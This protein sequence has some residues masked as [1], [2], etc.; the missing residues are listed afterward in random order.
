MSC[1]FGA[2][3]RYSA[4]G[5]PFFFQRVKYRSVSQYLGDEESLKLEV[6]YN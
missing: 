2:V 1:S 4:I 3:L 5:S 6:N